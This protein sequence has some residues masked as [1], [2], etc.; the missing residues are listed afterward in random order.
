MIRPARRIVELTY[1]QMALYF[2]TWTSGI[3]ANGYVF[4]LPPAT[5]LTNL[6]VVAHAFSGVL[7]LGVG[8]ALLALTWAH[9]SRRSALCALAAAVA[10]ASAEVSGLSFA[11]GPGSDIV[12]M[13]MAVGFITAVFMTFFSSLS[14]REKT[15]GREDDGSGPRQEG[16]RPLLHILYME[17]FLFCL[18][19]LSGMYVNLWVAGG[20][21]SMPPAVARGMLAGA[22][23]SPPFAAHAML[24]ILLLGAGVASTASL[25]RKGLK[26]WLFLSVA[27]TSL[28]GYSA[29]V[30]VLNMTALSDGGYLVF[31]VVPM[32]SAAGFMASLLASVLLTTEVHGASAGR[33][34]MP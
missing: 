23:Y 21:F 8:M 20:I 3:Y 5:L 17:L 6:A 28:I 32:L 9:G 27:S 22:I 10:I 30:G 15:Q 29:L 19:F 31:L 1:V 2:A 13:A 33:R 7:T 24:G 12:S 11:L 26:R 18:V 14:L 4:V 34:A 16:V 25:W